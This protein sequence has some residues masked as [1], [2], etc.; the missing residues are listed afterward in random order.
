MRTIGIEYGAV[1]ETRFY[2]LGEPP[3]LKPTEILV[4]TEYSGITNGTER[5]AL[6]A[7]HGWQG[8]GRHGYQHV[9]RVVR[10]GSAVT[11][12][13]VGNRVFVGHY[14]GH[15]GWQVV[16]LAAHH[17]VAFMNPLVIQIPD[18]IDP[19]PCAL[20]GVAGVAMRGIRR[21]RVGPAQRVWVVGQGL[22]GH[23]AAQSARALGAHV[24]VSDID[25]RRLDLARQCG[26]HRAL[27]AAAPEFLETL[28]Q[29]GPYDCIVDCAGIGTLMDTILDNQL[30][31][32]QGVIG[33]LAVRTHT[34][35]HWGMLHQTEASIE[36]SCHFSCDDLRVLL[37]F[38]GQGVIDA[39]PVITHEVSIDA[40]PD[41]YAILRD[42]PS[43]LLGVVFDWTQ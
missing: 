41:V 2:E 30:L 26:A 19:K 18:E 31:A 9:G 29:G 1:G 36:V 12:F 16:D 33:L 43:A 24:T 40:A 25:P 14:V 13:R 22:I 38:M 15:R 6:M 8:G 4:A 37:H 10:V 28:T 21:F 7:E 17:A 39:A 23:F 27:D 35:F 42:T 11:G 5:H 32:Y 3:A 34:T 20:L